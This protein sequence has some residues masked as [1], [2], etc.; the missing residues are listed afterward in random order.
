MTEY[1]PKVELRVPRIEHTGTQSHIIMHVD[2]ETAVEII[3]SDRGWAVNRFRNG[4]GWE[5]LHEEA[6][7]GVEQ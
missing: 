3:C 6:Q 7:R 2:H 1:T 5:C 4:E